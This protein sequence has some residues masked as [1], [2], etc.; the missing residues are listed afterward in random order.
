MRASNYALDFAEALSQKHG[1]TYEVLSGR[2][3][4]RIIRREASGHGGS[5]HAFVVR[6]TGELVKPASWRAPQKNSDGTLS[7][8]FNLEDPDDAQRAISASDPF[9]SYLYCTR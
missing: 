7:V 8:R 6:R 9:G 5:V 2:T 4:D 1:G 3:Y